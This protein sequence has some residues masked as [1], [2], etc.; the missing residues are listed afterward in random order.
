MNQFDYYA[1]SRP[2]ILNLLNFSF[3]TVLDVGCG[4]GETAKLIKS[5]YPESEFTG[6]DMYCDPHFNYSNIFDQ[7]YKLDITT[8]LNQLDRRNYDLVLMLDVLEHLVDPYSFLSKFVNDRSTNTKFIISLPNFFN[9]SNLYK[10]IR[11]ANFEYQ[12]SGI[13]DK[14]HLRF[15][16][17]INAVK[18][19]TDSGLK[20]IKL[21]QII[22]STS[23]KSKIIKMICGSDYVAY[24]NIFLCVN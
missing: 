21:D 12:D 1:S 8:E 11:S 24:Q 18:L 5:H 14:T 23:I 7:F 17:R 20:I 16:G 13:L 4:K 2:E 15:F 10:I 19:L 22:K 9:Y 3:N 6:V